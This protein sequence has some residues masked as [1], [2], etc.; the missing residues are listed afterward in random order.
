[1]CHYTTGGCWQ[2]SRF[3]D[4]KGTVLFQNNRIIFIVCVKACTNICEGQRLNGWRTYINLRVARGPPEAAM[5]YFVQASPR[6]QTGRTAHRCHLPPSDHCPARCAPSAAG[7]GLSS[8]AWWHCDWPNGCKVGG[9]EK[10]HMNG[11][12]WKGEPV[13]RAGGHP[14]DLQGR[15]QATGH[16]GDLVETCLL[17]AWARSHSTGATTRD[18]AVCRHAAMPLLDDFLTFDRNGGCINKQTKKGYVLSNNF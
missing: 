10:T 9:R 16:P 17:P 14:T 3:P 7:G 4:D 11:K 15:W 1:M 12:G 18:I 5:W 13:C 8:A 6:G 2:I